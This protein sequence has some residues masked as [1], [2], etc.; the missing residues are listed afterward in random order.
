MLKKSLLY[1][2]V[3]LREDKSIVC[4]A[5]LKELLTLD[6]QRLLLMLFLSFAHFWESTLKQNNKNFHFTALCK[7]MVCLIV[8]QVVSK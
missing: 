7:A 3:V 4:R 2:L 1:R 5:E 8:L 6:A